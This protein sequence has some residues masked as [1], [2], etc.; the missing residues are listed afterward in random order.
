MANVVACT[1]RR[2]K[3]EAPDTWTRFAKFMGSPAD[4][5]RERPLIDV[6]IAGPEARLRV[7]QVELPHPCEDLVEAQLRQR[8]SSL[9]EPLAPEPQ[10]L[11]VM[12][13]QRRHV[14]GA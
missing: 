6:E 3:A 10:G 11:G 12:R 4:L 14:E 9:K 5:A 8:V 13:S 1:T 7:R 2:P